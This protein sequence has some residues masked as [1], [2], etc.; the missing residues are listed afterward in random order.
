MTL[1]E[2]L[3]QTIRHVR[4]GEGDLEL[5]VE[6]PKGYPSVRSLEIVESAPGEVR[7]VLLTG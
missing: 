5:E 7:A 1:G 2:L 3:D 6:T 4:D